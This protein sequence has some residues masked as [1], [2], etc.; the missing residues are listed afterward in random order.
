MSSENAERDVAVTPSIVE[1]L[2]TGGAELIYP[3]E[4][5][6]CVN[7]S[8]PLVDNKLELTQGDCSMLDS[9]GERV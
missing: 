1:K 9:K 4:S 3:G 6:S 7:V 8:R 5:L 2:F